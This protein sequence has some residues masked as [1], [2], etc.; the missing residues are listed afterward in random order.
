MGSNDLSYADAEDRA[1][2]RITARARRYATGTATPA[3]DAAV[4]GEWGALEAAALAEAAAADD[5]A[6]AAAQAGD[7][8]AYEAEAQHA[9]MQHS[10]AR[11]ARAT[12]R[13]R[14]GEG[15]R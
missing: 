6:R 5:R 12:R 1:I 8:E 7:V 4:A 15:G 9:R 2:D 11:L 13:Q 3:D 14:P 10:I